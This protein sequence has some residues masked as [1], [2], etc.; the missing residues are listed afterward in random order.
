M[1]ILNEWFVFSLVLL[2]I[3]F[4]FFL[5][6]RTTRKRMLFVSLL[7]MPFGLT[8]P[9]FV[10]EYWNP[11]SLFDLA[12]RTGFDIESFIFCFAL[13]G[14]GTITYDIVFKACKR[15][16]PSHRHKYHLASLFSPIV[17]FMLLSLFKWLNPIYSASAAMLVG[18]ILA[19][20]RTPDLKKE[21]ITGGLLFLLLYSLS[22]LFCT[23]IYPYAV[24]RFW[25]LPSL[26]GILLLGIPLEELF[27]AFAFALM[28]SS[29]Y[30][31]IRWHSHEMD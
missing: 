7:T 9:L 5:A 26:S 21:I 31:H 13:G 11:P 4:V 22:F 16:Q 14:I 8:E 12:A 20:F 3:W 18:G 29:V 2:G 19:F 30:E 24:E 23:L 28:W 27:F 15:E 25:N 10:P 17:V 1:R 6:E